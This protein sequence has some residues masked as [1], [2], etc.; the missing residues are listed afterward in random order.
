MMYISIKISRL[1]SSKFYL[2]ILFGLISSKT[3]LF[4]AIESF[5]VFRIEDPFQDIAF[6]QPEKDSS[7]QRKRD[8]NYNLIKNI[9]D[10]EQFYIPSARSSLINEI[11]NNAAMY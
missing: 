3:E 4:H 11:I 5:E 10:H 1:E 9:V 6:I 7:S 2:N 8:E